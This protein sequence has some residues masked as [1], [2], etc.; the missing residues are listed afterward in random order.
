M[1]FSKIHLASETIPKNL[2]D[3]LANGG[4]L[5]NSINYLLFEV[6]FYRKTRSFLLEDQDIRNLF[7]LIKI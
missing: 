2:T 5:V 4:R 6:F 3:Q 1:L 7:M